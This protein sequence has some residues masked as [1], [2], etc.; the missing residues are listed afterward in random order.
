MPTKC[1]KCNAD[2]PDTKQ[3]CG[4]CGTQLS[5]VSVTKTLQTP[6][7]SLGKT[8]AGKYKILSELGRGG[9][10]IVY[11]ARQGCEKKDK[12]HYQTDKL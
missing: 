4:D 8:I 7:A 2:S 6:P 12:E 11:K 10:G 9:M 1:P 5:S 3:Y